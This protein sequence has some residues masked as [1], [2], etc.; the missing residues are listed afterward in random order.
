MIDPGTFR[1]YHVSPT[2]MKSRND[3]HYNYCESRDLGLAIWDTAEL[4]E[5]IKYLATTAIGENLY[6]ALDDLDV[7]KCFGTTSDCDG[8]LIWRQ[9]RTGTRAYYQKNKAYDV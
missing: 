6:T 3:E 9:T 5:D 2:K 1:Q 4:Y 8:E 7:S